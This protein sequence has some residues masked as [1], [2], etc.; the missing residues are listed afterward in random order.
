MISR[1][2]RWHLRVWLVLAPLLLF[3]IVA[4]LKVKQSFVRTHSINTSGPTQS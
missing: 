3:G 4:G 1:Q 2:R